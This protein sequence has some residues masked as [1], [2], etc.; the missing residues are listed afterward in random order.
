MIGIKYTG[1]KALPYSDPLY[2]TGF[3]WPSLDAVV[4]MEEAIAAKFLKH[5]DIFVTVDEEPPA[6]AKLKKPLIEEQKD[7]EDEETLPPLVQ[8]DVMDKRELIQFAQRHFGQ[9]LAANMNEENMR[10]R[11]RNWMNSPVAGG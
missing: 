10:S 3:V 6:A 4:W 7:I 1:R 8:L 5:P 9:K 2:K 11:I